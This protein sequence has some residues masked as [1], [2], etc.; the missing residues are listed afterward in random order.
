[1]HSSNFPNWMTYKIKISLVITGL[2][3]AALAS[4]A[5]L[6]YWRPSSPDFQ[7]FVIVTHSENELQ[8][9]EIQHQPS[10][11]HVE[12]TMEVIQDDVI[13]IQKAT[14]AR[15]LY[16]ELLENK[17]FQLALENPQ[18]RANID[19]L[20]SHPEIE[21]KLNGWFASLIRSAIFKRV[22]DPDFPQLVA[23]PNYVD[24]LFKQYGIA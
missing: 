23:A 10:I 20:L 13:T 14:K 15:K 5:Y 6:V 3:F 16:M 19:R 2:I 11:I 9:S 22:E 24:D 7:P 1:M 8:T 18:A 21:K 17:N 12:A 4:C